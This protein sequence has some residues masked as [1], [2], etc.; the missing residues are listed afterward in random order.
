MASMSYR[1]LRALLVEHGCKYLRDARHGGHELWV[2]P[3][4]QSF[5]VPKKL[6]GEGTLQNILKASGV[7]DRSASDQ[8]SQAD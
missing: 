2:C 7:R 6:K 5:S 4:S 8:A 1:E 3:G